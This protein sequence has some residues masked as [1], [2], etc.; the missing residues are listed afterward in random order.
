MCDA[1][2]LEIFFTLEG[3]EAGFFLRPGGGE[4]GERELEFFLHSG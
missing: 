4:G 2:C 1:L 3:E